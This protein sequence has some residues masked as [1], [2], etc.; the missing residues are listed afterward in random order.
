VAEDE[1]RT[2]LLRRPEVD[3]GGPVGRVDGLGG[4]GGNLGGGARWRPRCRRRAS[5]SI[6][7]AETTHC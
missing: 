4:R 5:G 1:E 6:L 7:S 3:A 2:R